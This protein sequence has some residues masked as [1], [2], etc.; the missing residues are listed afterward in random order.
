MNA[1]ANKANNSSVKDMQI[2][3]SLKNALYLNRIED[4][5]H[6]YQYSPQN[7]YNLYRIGKKSFLSI[8]SELE[9]L[10][11]DTSKYKEFIK[12]KRRSIFTLYPYPVNLM[13]FLFGEGVIINKNIESNLEEILSTLPE[14]YKKIIYLRFKDK[15]TLKECG[16][17]IHCSYSSVYKLQNHAAQMLKE[18]HR[19][20]YL[21]YKDIP[22]PVKSKSATDKIL[23]LPIIKLG[24]DKK[25]ET[26][27]FE[28]NIETMEELVKNI[29]DIRVGKKTKDI[30]VS[31]IKMF[32]FRI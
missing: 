30:L 26:V 15:L 13:Y 6:L 25:T 22:I 20:K 10:G 4:S 7:L 31:K 18:K 11:Y 23:S 16:E 19:A 24:F 17:I 29:N 32:G 1:K 5:D 28:Q 12:D 2:S 8:I 3:N 9:R 14:H 21:L 27:L